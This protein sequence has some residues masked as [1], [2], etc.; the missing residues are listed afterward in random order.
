MG[1]EGLRMA[2]PADASRVPDWGRIALFSGHTSLAAK[3]LGLRCSRLLQIHNRKFPNSES[4]KAGV[5]ALRPLFI[6]LGLR[7]RVTVSDA[8]WVAA[9]RGAVRSCVLRA[10]HADWLD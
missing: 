2:I 4:L 7:D 6:R 8:Q 1:E 5:R 10:S 9:S 3:G